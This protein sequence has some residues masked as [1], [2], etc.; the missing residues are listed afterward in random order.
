MEYILPFLSID[1]GYVIVIRF[2]CS[3]KTKKVNN[4]FDQTNKKKLF[5]SH[6]SKNKYEKKN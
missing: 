2:V 6:E 1:K 5:N 3:V 4:F